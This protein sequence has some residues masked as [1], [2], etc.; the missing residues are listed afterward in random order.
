MIG[1]ASSE[2]SEGLSPFTLLSSCVTPQWSPFV[3]GDVTCGVRLSDDLEL[4][5]EDGL[6]VSILGSRCVY[7][8]EPAEHMDHF[9][10]RVLTRRGVLIP[11]CAE[12]NGFAGTA[13][14]LEFHFRV[15]LV[16]EKIFFRYARVLDLA[17]F[18]AAGLAVV[19]ACGA[20]TKAARTSRR[21]ACTRY[22][23]RKRHKQR[24]E[25]EYGGWERDGKIVLKRLAWNAE[26]YLSGIDLNKG[27]AALR[28]RLET[29]ASGNL[30]NWLSFDGNSQRSVSATRARADRALVERS[31]LAPGAVV[32]CA[33]CRSKLSRRAVRSAGPERVPVAAGQFRLCM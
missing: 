7:C 30:R 4:G 28:V 21:P 15:Q 27:F 10:P 19:E 26:R 25:G 8:G 1:F 33:M 20:F 17:G 29:S 18:G 13:F 32:C 16:K 31:A 23:R 24:R 14:P 3:R 12:C 5:G 2:V 6:R 11:A 9:P 22:G